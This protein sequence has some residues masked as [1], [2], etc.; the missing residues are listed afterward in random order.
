M[1]KFKDEKD[2]TLFFSL[3]SSLILIYADLNNYA[4]ETHGIN[5]VIT[6]T[7]STPDEDK[8][9]GRTSPSHRE[10]RAL[11]I[12]ANDLPQEVVKELCNYINNKWAYRK[13]HYLSNSGVTRLAYPHGKGDNY[14]IHLAIHSR[15]ALK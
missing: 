14:H 6:D 13:Y 3:H 4:Y 8:K 15:F 12:R 5:L 9:I 7:I 1:I 11:D 10:K 2:M